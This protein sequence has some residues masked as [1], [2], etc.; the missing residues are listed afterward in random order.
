M[1]KYV[2]LSIAFIVIATVYSCST[3]QFTV[4]PSQDLRKI[5][6]NIKISI[7]GEAVSPDILDMIKRHTKGQLII[8]G[9]EVVE[10]GKDSINLNIHVQ[11][12]NP[13]SQAARILIGFGAGRGSLLYSAQFVDQDGKVLVSVNSQER[14]TG[15][16]VDFNMK[17]GSTTGFRGAEVV[18][19]TLCKE[20]AEHIVEVALNQAPDKPK[21][22]NQG[23]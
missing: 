11:S 9:F 8:A 20:A 1:K 6:S 3:K 23:G 7:T 21:N 4:A 13:G 14:F 18:Q 2:K 15:G 10:D 22:Q 17:Y 12:F 5:N 19:T 16:E